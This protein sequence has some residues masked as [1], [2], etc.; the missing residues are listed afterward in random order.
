MKRKDLSLSRETLFPR[1]FPHG[2]VCVETFQF[3]TRDPS[4]RHSFAYLAQ[5]KALLPPTGSLLRNCNSGRNEEDFLEARVR[6]EL[7]H[8]GFAD[9][10]LTTWVPRHPTEIIAKLT[11]AVSQ[12][13][14]AFSHFLA[15]VAIF[16]SRR[17]RAASS[18]GVGLI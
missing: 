7:T 14:A 9:L 13:E 3:G 6:I 11:W 15:A 16:A 10:S 5:A 17:N 4:C 12:A 8:K 2:N 18:G 1:P